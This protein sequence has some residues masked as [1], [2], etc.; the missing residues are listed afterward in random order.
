MRPTRRAR[1]LLTIL[2][3]VAF[4]LVT[5][6]Y[7][8]GAL[9]GVR[10]AV[11]TVFG[12]VEDGVSAVVSPIGSW[13]SSVGHLGS[14]RDDNKKLT[15]ELADARAQLHL[16]AHDQAQLAQLQRIFHL[17]GDAKYKVVAAK[18]TAYGSTQSF[19][20]SVTINRGSGQGITTGETVLDGDG[21]VG[22]TTQV[23]RDSSTVLLGCDPSFT[24]GVSVGAATTQVGSVTGGGR[25]A[26]ALTMFSTVAKLTKNEPVVTLGS[27]KDKPFVPEVPVG[28]VSQV[29][30][31]TGASSVTATVVPYVDYTALDMVAVV[32]SAPHR[33]A[34]DSLVPTPHPTPTV[35]KTVTASPSASS[36]PSTSSTP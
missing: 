28:R 27:S 6:D 3:L 16:T 14:Y 23:S 32:V 36:S 18:V 9:G 2:I 29:T 7:R 26:M 10:N 1:L 35:T 34:H 8:S 31:S 4:S 12:P 13:F 17:A 21:L 24:V 25:G 5:L 15:K 20:C 33:P 30:Q 11:G 19:E 22:R